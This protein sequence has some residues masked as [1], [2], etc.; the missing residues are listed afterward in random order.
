[1]KNYRR[2]GVVATLSLG[3]FDL[4]LLDGVLAPKLQDYLRDQATIVASDTVLGKRKGAQPVPPSPRVE[5]KHD[6]ASTGRN[7]QADSDP[8]RGDTKLQDRKAVET[9][10]KSSEPNDATDKREI[11]KPVTPP[12]PQLKTI[13]FRT[14]STH[15]RSRSRRQLKSIAKVMAKRDGLRLLIRGHA[16]QRGRASANTDLSERRAQAVARRLRALGVNI[17]RMDIEAVGEAELLSSENTPAAWARNRRVELI[18][19]SSP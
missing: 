2:F 11:P 13:A 4:A 12:L 10:N 1:M 14:A 3:F 6:L 9:A 19:R 7:D 17:D 16:D 18:W 8:A 15:I 5:S